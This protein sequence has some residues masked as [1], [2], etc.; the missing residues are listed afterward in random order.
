MLPAVRGAGL[1]VRGEHEAGRVHVHVLQV[2]QPGLGRG[3]QAPV[4]HEAGTGR[5]STA[6]EV[7]CLILNKC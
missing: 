5:T 2:R 4:H 7:S 1:A 3:S 6:G